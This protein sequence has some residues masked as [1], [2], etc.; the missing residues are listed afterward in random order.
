MAVVLRCVDSMLYTMYSDFVFLACQL[1]GDGWLL[2]YAPC[3]V[4]VC[5]WH[6]SVQ[7]GM[8]Q[9]AKRSCVE[10]G[11]LTGHSQKQQT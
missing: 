7:S 1:C 3:I 6:D 11:C 4:I 5:S 2:Y 10:M 9:A 8:R